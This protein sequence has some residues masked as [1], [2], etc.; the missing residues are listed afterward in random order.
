MDIAGYGV[1]ALISLKARAFPYLGYR[2][3]DVASRLSF[4]LQHTA[5]EMAAFDPSANVGHEA[6]DL[7]KNRG[8]LCVTDSS[9]KLLPVLPIC[10]GWHDGVECTEGGVTDV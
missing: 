4:S 1:T 2:L 10:T 8:V 3:T 5:D 9:A 7:W 6:G